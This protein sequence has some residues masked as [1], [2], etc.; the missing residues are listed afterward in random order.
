MASSDV[1]SGAA[2]RAPRAD[3]RPVGADPKVSGFGTLRRTLKEF[4]QDNLTD[5]AAALT[6][7]GVLALFPALI[8]LVS[9]VGLVGDPASTT[10]ALTDVVT[11]LGPAS[12]AE[13]LKDPSWRSRPTAAAPVSR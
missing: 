10:K 8:A 1:D 12:A 6:Y 13:A 4:N 9:V 11:Q 7:Y 3:S 2:G 5:W